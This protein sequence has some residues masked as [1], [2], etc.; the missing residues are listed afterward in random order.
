MNQRMHGQG[1]RYHGTLGG[2]WFGDFFYYQRIAYLIFANS[3]LTGAFPFSIVGGQDYIRIGRTM[4]TGSKDAIT[5]SQIV[6][7]A[8]SAFLFPIRCFSKPSYIQ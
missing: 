2:A 3:S 7:E 6:S 1:A 4:L 5:T 8:T